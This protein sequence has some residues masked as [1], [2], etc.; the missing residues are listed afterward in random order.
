MQTNN[1]HKAVLILIFIGSLIL[2]LGLS[3]FNREANDPH[4]PVIRQIMRNNELPD[5]AD[6]WEC[7]QPKLFHYTIAKILDMSG[8]E[9]RKDADAQKI[10]AQLVNFFCGHGCAV[11]H[12]GV[13]QRDP[14]CKFH[15]KDACVCTIGI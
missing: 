10:V 8:L 12:V 9:G 4:M 6:C 15:D 3:L 7:F 2:R 13:Y 14:Q 1:A 5:K 11:F